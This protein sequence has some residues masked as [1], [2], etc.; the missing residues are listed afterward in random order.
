MAN[1]VPSPRAQQWAQQRAQQ[2]GS[3]GSLVSLFIRFE[4]ESMIFAI[5]SLSFIYAE[6]GIGFVRSF[7]QSGSGF[8]V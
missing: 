2:L 4:F 7:P 6:T 8:C 1:V 3:F 5:N